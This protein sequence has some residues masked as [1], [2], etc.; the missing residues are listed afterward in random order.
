MD[1]R[2]AGAVVAMYENNYNP[3]D[4]IE[5][6]YVQELPIEKIDMNE[7]VY[8]VDYSFSKNTAEF[9]RKILKITDNVIWIDHHESSLEML[10]ENID[11]RTIK[12]YVTEGISGAALTYMYLYKESY[13]NIPLVLKYVS[14]YDCHHLKL[15]KVMEFKY[16]IESFDHNPISDLWIKL[17][18]EGDDKDNKVLDEV[19]ENGE[20]VKRY[21]DGINRELRNTLS[22]ETEIDGYKALVVNTSYKGSA[23]FG[24]EISNYDVCMV[25]RYSKGNYEYSVY[26]E[27]IDVSKLAE[28]YGGGGHPGAAG[29]VLKDKLF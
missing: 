5:V 13:D 6:D 10:K 1:G 25:W 7:K 27:K 4:Y 22:Y 9:L 15:D 17:L 3:E 26:S 28:K 12:G 20:I 16:G 21:I 24:D 18:N 8:F 14:D 29:F 11:L 2:S 23:I 19:V